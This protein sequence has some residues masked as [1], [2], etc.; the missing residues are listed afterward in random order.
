MEHRHSGMQ[1]RWGNDAADRNRI[2][3]WHIA[4]IA[5]AGQDTARRETDLRGIACR[6]AHNVATAE[7]PIESIGMR[8]RAENRR[9][10]C[11]GSAALVTACRAAQDEPSAYRSAVDRQIGP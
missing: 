2:F 9:P 5:R 1:L 11:K 6:A 4:A 8:G 3:N 10:T 7:V